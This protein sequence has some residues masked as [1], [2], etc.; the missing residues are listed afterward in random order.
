MAFAL[1][2]HDIAKRRDRLDPPP[3]AQ[4][5]GGAALLHAAA[6]NLRVLRLN[7][8]RHVRHGEVLRAE[9]VGVEQ[10]VDLTGAAAHD[11]DLSDAADALELAAE[12]LVG[13]LGDVADRRGGR[14]GER[15]HR[16]RIGVELLDRRLLDGARQAGKHA[17]HAI[18]H[19]LGGDVTVLLEQERDD[20]L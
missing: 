16:C 1:V 2:D 10:D 11:D 5:H 4:R 17:V 19:F 15:H 20:D 3:R 18:T 9:P 13:V 6:G 14:D 8:P 12:H 7:R